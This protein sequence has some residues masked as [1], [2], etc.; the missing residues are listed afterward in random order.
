MQQIAMENKDLISIINQIENVDEK[1]DFAEKNLFHDKFN[2]LKQFKDIKGENEKIDFIYEFARDVDVKS[3]TLIQTDKKV[4]LKIQNEFVITFLDNF[5]RIITDYK[6]TNSEM[7]V[8]LYMLRK[9][10][11]GN[12]LI[13]KQSSVCEAL[14]IKKANM[15]HIFK[16]L[17]DKNILITDEE[18]NLYINSNIFMKGLPHKLNKEK[19]RSLRKSQVENEKIKK[20]Y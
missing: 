20:S 10:E 9:M 6:I 11:F 8:V 15:S 13:L 17:K 14:N 18:G 12:L 19:I 3:T 7:R 1:I 16:S 2:I 4:S 5:D